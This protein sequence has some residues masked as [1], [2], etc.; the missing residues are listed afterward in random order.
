MINFGKLNFTKGLEEWIALSEVMAPKMLAVG[1]QFQFALA[2]P[3]EDKL[4]LLIDM[5]GDIEEILNAS[6][7]PKAIE[8]REAAGVKV[9][10]QEMISSIDSSVFWEKDVPTTS[11][12]IPCMFKMNITMRK[13][14]NIYSLLG[15]TNLFGVVIAKKNINFISKQKPHQRQTKIMS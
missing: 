9:E 7:N 5:N 8:M 11:A 12:K 13:Q 2:N 3:I 15:L 1:M 10:T 6:N 4:F 14:P